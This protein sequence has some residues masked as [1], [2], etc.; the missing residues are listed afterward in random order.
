MLSPRGIAE[1]HFK[2]ASA[3]AALFELRVRLCAGTIAPARDMRIDT[4]LSVV[5][6]ALL[7][8]FKPILGERDVELL[9]NACSLRNKMLHCEFSAA[10]QRLDEQQPKTRHGGVMKLDVANPDIAQQSLADTKTKTLG[11]VFGWLLEF[12]SAD[13]FKEATTVFQA[14]SAVLDKCVGAPHSR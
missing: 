14:A 8:H 11:D 2:T 4:S 13:E 10:R 1:Q 5:R 7:E 12:Q 3:E 9:Q 6:D